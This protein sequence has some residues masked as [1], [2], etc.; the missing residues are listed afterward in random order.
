MDERGLP[1][2]PDP[3]DVNNISR[4]K[5]RTSNRRHTLFLAMEGPGVSRSRSRVF[6]ESESKSVWSNVDETMEQADDFFCIKEEK[7]LLPSHVRKKRMSAILIVP[8]KPEKEIK[9]E[10]V[11]IPAASFERFLNS[12]IP[13]CDVDELLSSKI[14][15]LREQLDMMLVQA[16]EQMD[17]IWEFT[18]AFA[19]QPF[20]ERNAR[21]R[22]A[23]KQKLY[24]EAMLKFDRSRVALIQA[25]VRAV[26]DLQDFLGQQQ[27]DTLFDYQGF[28]KE[29]LLQ[30]S[31]QSAKWRG[32]AA[33]LKLAC[34]METETPLDKKT[35]EDILRSPD[36]KSG[37][38]LQRFEKVLEEI[39]YND[40]EVIMKALAPEGENTD[41]VR[42]VMFAIAW[43]KLVF[44]FAD[45]DV[46]TFPNILNETPRFVNPPYLPES[47]LDTPFNEING[48]EW[49]L[50]ERSLA[51]FELMLETDPFVIAD[52]YW[53]WVQGLANDIERLAIDSGCEADD[54]EIGFDCLF[55]YTLLCVF[56]F[57]VSEILEVMK[58][59]SSFLEFVGADAH[60]QFAMTNCLAVVT[61]IARLAEK[62]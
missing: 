28:E 20:L 10:Q 12:G 2:I 9:Y 29:Y 44:P 27:N 19:S 14:M 50:R 52:L 7:S 36:E 57:G 21:R 46:M 38:I 59:T 26:A 35:P 8:E 31:K 24:Y 3:P 51:L 15:C 54:V 25:K 49:P 34:S 61:Y 45:V 17:R 4:K 13:K 18:Q 48:T 30:E 1:D 41:F 56:A 47:A 22:K 23:V 16:S 53:D 60:K 62:E 5:R 32:R 42:G 6:G 11:G 33:R 43:G 40:C 39:D 37:R 58:F 55:R